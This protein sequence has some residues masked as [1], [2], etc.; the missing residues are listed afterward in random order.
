[1]TTKRCAPWRTRL[2]C[3]SGLRPP[4]P[5]LRATLGHLRSAMQASPVTLATVPDELKRD[6]IASDGRARIEVFPKGDA[7]DNQTL[8][9]FVAAVTLLAPEATGRPGSIQE[10][11]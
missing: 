1:M 2:R 7:N 6:W 11:S 5:G 9:R 4:I 8:R 3:S 10:S